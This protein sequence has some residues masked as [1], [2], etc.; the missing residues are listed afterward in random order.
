MRTPSSSR[1]NSCTLYSKMHMPGEPGLRGTGS[2]AL[3]LREAREHGLH[4]APGRP[5]CA[6][7]KRVSHLI[8]YGDL[9]PGWANRGYSTEQLE[10]RRRMWPSRGVGGDGTSQPT[11][12][13][14]PG[15][16]RPT[17][18]R[19]RRGRSTTCDACR[20][21]LENAVKFFSLCSF[22]AYC[23][24]R[25]RPLLK[26]RRQAD[27]FRPLARPHKNAERKSGN[28]NSPENPDLCSCGHRVEDRWSVAIRGR[29]GSRGG[30]W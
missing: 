17:R 1:S 11:G 7:P 29:L 23:F 9:R 14:S 10:H 22:S 20:R 2:R 12:S 28:S 13:F 5:A 21:P 27:T 4:R 30:A 16:L 19:F 26:H 18:P 3:A 6:I 15:H 25:A 8:L 24:V